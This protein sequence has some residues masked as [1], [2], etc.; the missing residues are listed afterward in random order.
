MVIV[1][2]FLMGLVALVPTEKANDN[3]LMVIVPNVITL[4]HHNHFP[5]FV[6]DKR[7]YGDNLGEASYIAQDL[8]LGLKPEEIQ[9]GGYLLDGQTIAIEPMTSNK[10]EFVGG[11]GK[12][13][14]RRRVAAAMP[15]V[16]N[17]HNFGWIPSMTTLTD[18]KGALDDR[19]FG[20]PKRADVAGQMQLRARGGR[21]M[22]YSFAGEGTVPSMRFVGLG[23]TPVQTCRQAVADVAVIEMT[24]QK[25]EVP[26]D[27]LLF[28]GRG[29]DSARTWSV[30]LKPYVADDGDRIDVLIGNLTPMETLSNPSEEMTPEQSL[31]FDLYNGMLQRLPNYRDRLLP[32]AGGASVADVDVDPPYCSLARILRL[33]SKGDCIKG[34]EPKAGIAR[35]ICM[36]ATFGAPD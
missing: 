7:S 5:V 3:K 14:S 13:P 8:Q 25:S 17:A 33:V 1:R 18:G 4:T 11:I 9:F 36:L 21:V 26:P 20:N 28:E 34:V 19:Y 31:H 2:I 32:V 29:Y 16:K 22:T 24:Y 10:L 27:G 30:K 6:W 23:W 35:P 12:G 15:D